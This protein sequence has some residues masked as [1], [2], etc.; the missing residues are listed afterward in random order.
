MMAPSAKNISRASSNG[1]EVLGGLE[2]L[3]QALSLSQNK[4][5]P[6]SEGPS[7]AR[8]SWAQLRSRI[9]SP[10]RAAP[11]FTR[12][13]A[14]CR[15]LEAGQGCLRRVGTAGLHGC[16][17]GVAKDVGQLLREGGPGLEDCRNAPGTRGIAG[18][19]ASMQT[20]SPPCTHGGSHARRAPSVRG[21]PCAMCFPRC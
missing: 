19:Q 6:G 3:K 16:G 7:Q 14:Y 8:N 12:R 9:R 5:R 11:S 13:P 10:L 2:T 20:P 4:W 17:A 1:P 21:R 18:N 15:V